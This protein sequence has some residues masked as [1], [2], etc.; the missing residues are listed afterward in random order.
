MARHPD[1]VDTEMGIYAND[2][3]FAKYA[4]CIADPWENEPARVPTGSQLPSQVYKSTITV[5]VQTSA[6]SGFGYIAVCPNTA[7]DTK[8]VTYSASSTSVINYIPFQTNTPAGYGNASFST[9]PYSA[10]NHNVYPVAGDATAV[11]SRVVACSM[12]VKPTTA[13]INRGGTIRIGQ[14]QGQTAAGVDFAQQQDLLVGNAHEYDGGEDGTVELRWQTGSVCDLDFNDWSTLYQNRCQ[15]FSQASAGVHAIE[16]APMY[17]IFQAP[18]VGGTYTGQT[19]RV[20]ICIVAEYTGFVATG[21]PIS[22]GNPRRHMPGIGDVR[23]AMVRALNKIT[24]NPQNKDWFD[25]ITGSNT[26]RHADD[27]LDY[28]LN[29]ANKLSSIAGNLIGFGKMK[30]QK[31]KPKQRLPRSS[32]TIEE[33]FDTPAPRRIRN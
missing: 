3:A 23:G 31:P 6:T 24:A 2:P 5:D 18:T 9:L 27:V 33:V 16:I 28:A 7:N 11:K 21:V 20:M 22:F 14:S 15:P 17:A 12:R 8:A 25:K 10:T 4:E 29:T 19:Y 26:A 13:M 32:V 1:L 30:P